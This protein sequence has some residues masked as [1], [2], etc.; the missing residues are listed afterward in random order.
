MTIENEKLLLLSE[1]GARDTS[2][3]YSVRE[4]VYDSNCCGNICC[5][6]HKAR[7]SF[8]YAWE[9]QAR[10]TACKEPGF[11]CEEK[12]TFLKADNA[13][14]ER[15]QPKDRECAAKGQD[16]HPEKDSFLGM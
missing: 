9:R 5:N 13:R 1:N 14:S 3:V 16:D 10:D 7:T 11:I 2:D 8:P 12:S 4:E 6:R 15:Y